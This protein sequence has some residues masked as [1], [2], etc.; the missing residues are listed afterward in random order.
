MTLARAGTLNVRRRL[1]LAIG[2]MV[3]LGALLIRARQGGL[4]L[5]LGDR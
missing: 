2:A 1:D 5:P 4:A 3:V